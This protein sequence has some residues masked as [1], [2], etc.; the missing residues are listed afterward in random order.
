[1]DPARE[2][3][4][5]EYFSRY[6]YRREAW[7]ATREI[8]DLFECYPSDEEMI[9]EGWSLVDGVWTHPDYTPPAPPTPAPDIPF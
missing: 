6:D 7:E 3:L 2:E 8:G 1:M 5:I 4:E 9:A